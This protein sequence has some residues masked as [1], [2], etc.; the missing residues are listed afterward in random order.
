VG[1]ITRALEQ[2]VILT[3]S[4]IPAG[5]YTWLRWIA[6]DAT[7]ARY[8]ILRGDGTTARS[9][10]ARVFPAG[11]HSFS[12]NGRLPNASGVLVAATPGRYLMRVLVRGPDGRYASLV[13]PVDVR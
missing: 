5:T 2:P 10:D 8:Q 7:N 4:S 12:W 1:P 11:R 13:A 9:F 3:S 6:S